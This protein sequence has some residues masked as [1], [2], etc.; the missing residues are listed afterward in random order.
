MTQKED[1]SVLSVRRSGLELVP[2]RKRSG[3]LATKRDYAKLDWKPWKRSPDMSSTEFIPSREIT[4]E[5]GITARIAYGF[6]L[7]SRAE[8]IEMHKT[9]KHEAEDELMGKLAQASEDFKAL[10]SMVDQAYVRILA[11]ASKHA[12][13]GGK[14][15]H[16][17]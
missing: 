4:D 14:F 2:R 5:L 3:R 11:S 13:N 8:L 12:L 9:I 1:S 10:A 6:M 7:R 17:G 15:K 16:A